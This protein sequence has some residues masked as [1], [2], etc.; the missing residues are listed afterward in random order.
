MPTTTGPAF[1]L[2]E[3]AGDPLSMYREDLY[4]VTANL[5]GLPAVSVPA[6]FA[7]VKGVEL[8]LGVQILGPAFADDLVLRVARMFEKATGYGRRA[9][10]LV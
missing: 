8:P 7:S 9:P 4:T 5:A 6:G 10:A 3:K 2:G 1:K